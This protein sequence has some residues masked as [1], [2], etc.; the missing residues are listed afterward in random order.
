MIEGYVNQNRRWSAA[1]T[2]WRR[3][4]YLLHCILGVVAASKQCSFPAD[5]D[6]PSTSHAIKFLGMQRH[7]INVVQASMTWLQP[8][9]V[10]NTLIV[11]PSNMEQL[12]LALNWRVW[13]AAHSGV[14]EHVVYQCLDTGSRDFLAK[15]G[16]PC[17][18][19]DYTIN[20]AAWSANPFGKD[21]N[22]VGS[23]KLPMLAALVQCSFDALL[24]DSDAFMLSH[25][26]ATASLLGYRVATHAHVIVTI[27]LRPVQ[28]LRQAR[29][30]SCISASR[31][32]FSA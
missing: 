3:R 6:E 4:M 24:V 20:T 22:R 31:R 1:D 26:C 5:L 27:L 30:A 8:R 32:H 13:A 10:D 12:D 28:P 2:K 23:W 18:F 14:A 7:A 21:W 16:E 17:L 29:R 15:R 11:V 9:T 19:T 25:P